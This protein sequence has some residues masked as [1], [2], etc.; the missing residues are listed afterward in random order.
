M[1]QAAAGSEV[2][3]IRREN[4]RRRS[5]ILTPSCR[6]TDATERCH[7]ETRANPGRCARIITG[8]ATI[9]IR[10]PDVINEGMVFPIAWNMLEATKIKPDATKFNEM[11]CRYSTPIPITAGSLEKTEIISAGQM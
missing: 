7:I 9:S 11:I 8:I 4:S 5:S 2:N 6:Y 1:A 3:A 10:I